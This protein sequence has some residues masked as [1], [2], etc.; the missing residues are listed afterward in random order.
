MR[1]KNKLVKISEWSFAIIVFMIMMFPI[2]WM[3]TNSLKFNSDIF[4]TPVDFFPMR[5]TIDAYI[6]QLNNKAY[7]IFASLKNSMIISVSTMILGVTIAVP[8]SYGLARFR[9]K[10]YKS[11]VMLFLTTQMMPQIFTLI[12]T[13]IIFAKIGITNTFLAPILANTLIAVP[14]CVIMLRTYFQGIPKEL[15]EAARIDGCGHFKSFLLIM[16]P[17]LKTGIA[18][19]AVFSFIFGYGDMVNSLTYNNNSMLWPITTGIYNYVGAYGIEWNKAMAFAV[20]ATVP[21]IAIFIA[22]KDYIV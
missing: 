12:P 13:Y 17:L 20:C 6:N 11:F 7:D 14:F 8:A 21:I 18:V 10:G 9:I 2:Y 16:V 15:D 19:S 1:R 3:I 22:L 5:V 4:K